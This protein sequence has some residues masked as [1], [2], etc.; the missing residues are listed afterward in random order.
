M[1]LAEQKKRKEKD[2]KYKVNRYYRSVCETTW[3]SERFFLNIKVTASYT[4]FLTTFWSLTH[5]IEDKKP[6]RSGSLQL[7]TN[8]WAGTGTMTQHFATFGQNRLMRGNNGTKSGSQAVE[9]GDF[10]FPEWS[11]LNSQQRFCPK[12][13]LLHVQKAGPNFNRFYQTVKSYKVLKRSTGN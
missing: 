9:S 10:L 13:H 2:Y 1:N 7:T 6:V 12:T 8:W 4:E 5:I 11:L 3:G